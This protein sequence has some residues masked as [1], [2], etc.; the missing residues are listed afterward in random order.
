M[1]GW[2]GQFAGP[3]YLDRAVS[4]GA[5]AGGGAPGGAAAPPVPQHPP[6]SAGLL[7]VVLLFLS[8]P[9]AVH[10]PATSVSEALLYAQVLLS[11][12]RHSNVLFTCIRLNVEVI[13]LYFI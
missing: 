2:M 13:F 3:V 7:C 12:C 5:A 4:R 9:N 11:L 10:V 6:R 8:P 1:C